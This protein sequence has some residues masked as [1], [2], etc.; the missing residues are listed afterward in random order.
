MADDEY[1]VDYIRVAFLVFAETTN[2]LKHF[3][4][5]TCI[6]WLKIEEIWI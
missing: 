1:P 6:P 2:V 3:K 5:I 4:Q